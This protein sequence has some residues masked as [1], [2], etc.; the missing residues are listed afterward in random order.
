MSETKAKSATPQKPAGSIAALLNSKT[1]NFVVDVEGI[2]VETAKLNGPVGIFFVKH[3]SICAE[4]SKILLAAYSQW[5]TENKAFEVV[6][7]CLDAKDGALVRSLPF[8]FRRLLQNF[9]PV[10]VSARPRPICVAGEIV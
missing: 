3:D 10:V 2:H 5:K 9:A 8:G 4:F 7:V 6:N 1:R